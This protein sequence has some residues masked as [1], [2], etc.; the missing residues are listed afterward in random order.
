[1]MIA[2]FIFA[3][4]VAKMKKIEWNPTNYILAYRVY[5]QPGRYLPMNY[6]GSPKVQ[7]PAC[8]DS[9]PRLWYAFIRKK[10]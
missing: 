10:R 9:C 6:R 2:F 8:T 5:S 3:L 1:M 7:T 4:I